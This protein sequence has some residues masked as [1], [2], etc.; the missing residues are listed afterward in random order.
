MWDVGHSPAQVIKDE[1]LSKQTDPK[2]IAGI[3]QETLAAQPQALADYQ[4]GSQKSFGFL[5]GQ[6][7]QRGRGSL[8]PQVLRNVLQEELER[9]AGHS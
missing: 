9:L 7:M 3:V 6:A 1:G 4:G 8:D 2:V 5:M